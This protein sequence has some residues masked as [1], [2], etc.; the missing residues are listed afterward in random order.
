MT[1]TLFETVL[2]TVN[3]ELVNLFITG[4]IK[5]LDLI[6]KLDLIVN[7]KEFKKYKLIKPRNINQIVDTMKQ[8]RLKTIKLCIK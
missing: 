5:Y 6:K 7:S 1:H 2:V 4:K 3:D 8:V